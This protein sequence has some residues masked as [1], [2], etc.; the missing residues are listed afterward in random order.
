MDLSPL[1]DASQI[2]HTRNLAA[3]RD[4]SRQ[5]KMR[6]LGIRQLLKRSQKITDMQKRGTQV[7]PFSI[8][9]F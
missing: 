4:I 8:F 1:S 2:C 7:R 5:M 6:L 3:K 9:E